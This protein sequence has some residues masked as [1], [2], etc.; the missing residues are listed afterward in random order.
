MSFLWTGSMRVVNHEC[1]YARPYA[2][3]CLARKWNIR[4]CFNTKCRK[5]NPKQLARQILARLAT[6][7]TNN[8]MLAK[9]CT[10]HWYTR[11]A[12]PHVHREK[13]DC[14]VCMLMRHSFIN[15]LYYWFSLNADAW[16]RI[17]DFWI[18]SWESDFSLE[19]FHL[20]FMIKTSLRFSVQLKHPNYL[21]PAVISAVAF[22]K[23]SPFLPFAWSLRWTRND[24]LIKSQKRLCCFCGNTY[25]RTVDL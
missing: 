12:Q 3:F 6:V 4:L 15:Q 10:A 25:F 2:V 9:H 21:E 1:F 13:L 16:I 19:M 24:K 17:L 7:N 23:M 8:Q 18:P 22:V 14:A 20:T 5:T 11:T